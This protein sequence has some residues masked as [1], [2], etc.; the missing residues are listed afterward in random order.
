MLCHQSRTHVTC[1]GDF[2]PRVSASPWPVLHHVTSRGDISWQLWHA[3]ITDIHNMQIDSATGAVIGKKRRCDLLNL[4]VTEYCV[5]DDVWTF[6][7]DSL[8]SQNYR[9]H[10]LL[11]YNYLGPIYCHNYF[12]TGW[13]MAGHS[14]AFTQHTTSSR[15]NFY[16]SRGCRGAAD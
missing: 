10:D 7:A 2:I 13:T 6:L 11:W 12:F 3:A 9:A 15:R 4:D 5:D 1:P 16:W 14:W 8:C